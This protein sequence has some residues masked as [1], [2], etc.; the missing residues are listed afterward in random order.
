MSNSYSVDA[1]G[2]STEER[3]R[4][5]EIRDKANAEAAANWHNKAWRAEMAANMTEVIFQG[6][7]HESF[8]SL[9]ADVQTVDFADRV[10]VREVRGMK[11]FWIARGGHIESSTIHA[12]AIDIPRDTIGFHVYEFE[13]KLRTNFAVSQ[14]DL[15]DLATQR[16]DAD[17]NTRVLRMYQAA[18]PSTSPFYFS[19]AGLDLA[20]LNTALSEVRDVSQDPSPVII[21]RSRMTDQIVDQLLGANNNGSGFLPETNERL[22][23]QG[24][25]GTYRGA[26][27]ITLKNFRDDTDTPYFPANEL[28]VTTKDASKFAFFGGLQAKE[29]D[30]D[31]NWYWHYVG[32][33]DFGGLVH[34]PH[35]L[36]RIVDT[37]ISANAGNEGSFT[38]P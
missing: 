18:I 16:M 10:T 30:E 7:E 3:K 4:L 12:E 26:K 37:S 1:S 27:I 28:F 11:T 19:G 21:G 5:A 36:R 23:S 17:I 20:V 35:H 25:L 31:V 2:R 32:R 29:S 6:F 22:L 15:I 33:R 24:V 14:A 38:T 34:R 9:L 13:D 8:L